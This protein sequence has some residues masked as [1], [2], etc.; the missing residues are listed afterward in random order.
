MDGQK[1]NVVM[2]AAVAHN[3]VI[4]VNGA[5]PWHIPSDF[6]HFKRITMGKPIIMGRK[7]YETLGKPLPG[8][9]NIVV[10]RQVGYQPEGVIVLNDFEAAV[11]HAKSIAM[12]DKVTGIMIIGG[13]EIYKLGMENADELVISHVDLDVDISARNEIVAFPEI[14]PSIWDVVENL[15]VLP[16]E[17]DQWTYSIKVYRRFHPLTH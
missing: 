6:A 16:F 3:G 12:A 9:V 1:I 8:R 7:Q 15:P 10:S 2:I 13:G 4:G 14:D 11:I 17:K 5:M